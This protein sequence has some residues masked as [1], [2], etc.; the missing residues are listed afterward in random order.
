MHISWT[1]HISRTVIVLVVGL[2]LA[3]CQ[4]G[5]EKEYG[6]TLLGA[7]LGALAGSQL[8]SGKGQL[9]AVAIGALA[10]GFFGNQIGQSLDK[11]DRLFAQDTAQTSLENNKT[12]Q[13]SAWRNPDS[14]N[15][16]SY[17]PTRTYVSNSGEDCREFEAVILVDGREE[18]A[19]GRACRQPDQTW[20]IIE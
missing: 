3:A 13:A 8:G 10:G 15:S 7:G 11:A 14:G 18:R 2:A 6:G 1:G 4:D 5:R 12:G 20:K 16:G 17:T 9:A 19:I